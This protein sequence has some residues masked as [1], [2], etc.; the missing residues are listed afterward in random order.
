[1]VSSHAVRVESIPAHMC[2][3]NGMP[4]QAR[5]WLHLFCARTARVRYLTFHVRLAG[6]LVYLNY[7]PCPIP[8][9]PVTTCGQNCEVK[10][11]LMSPGPFETIALG[12]RAGTRDDTEPFLS[13]MLQLE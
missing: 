3:V 5:D 10:K 13:S 8:S 6:C 2:H 12:T 9:E 4:S 7:L 1:M 11:S